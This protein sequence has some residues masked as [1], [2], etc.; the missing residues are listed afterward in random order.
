MSRRWCKIVSLFAPGRNRGLRRRHLSIFSALLFVGASELTAAAE[1]EVTL[2]PSGQFVGSAGCKS[3]SCH[4]GAGEKRSQFITWS[5]QDFHARAFAVLV[6]ARS[7]R[8]ADTLHL[9]QAQTSPRCTVCHSPLQSVEPSR[10]TTAA[11]TE[12]NV[13]CESCHNAA[14]AW[15]R[16]HTR[17]DWTYATRVTAGMR[18]LQNLYVRANT[19]VACHQN[20]DADLLAAGHPE[21]RF[22]LDGQSVAEPKHWKDDPNSGAKAWLVGQAV[23]LREMSWGLSR[24][25]NPDNE[26]VARWSAL[27]WL[28]GKVTTG[29]TRMTLIDLPN[30][31]IVRASFID[32]QARTDSFARN[33]AALSLGETFAR[34]TLDSLLNLH[35]ELQQSSEADATIFRRAE[36]LVPAV[37]RLA[38][39]AGMDSDTSPRPERA[40]V[41][42]ALHA[43][44]TFDRPIFLK[45]LADYRQA[46]TKLP[47]DR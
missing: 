6:N 15:L 39:A 46:L 38:T 2:R 17:S 27:V 35:Q 13:S 41:I 5:Q 30:G 44:A 8:I 20:L 19:C 4:G 16:G 3:S 45:A 10:L 12:Q 40:Q 21:L 31:P 47:A 23:A 32:M 37:I 22:E 18:D 9:G 11:K 36:R 14:S 25:D 24:S 34:N 26:S 29:Q 33:T 7:A 43:N 42:E 1:P 28:L